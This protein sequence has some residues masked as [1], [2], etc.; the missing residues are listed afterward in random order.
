MMLMDY[1]CAKECKNTEESFGEIC[2][3]CEK[4]GRKF[5]DGIMIDDGGTHP[6]WDGEQE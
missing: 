2:L 5:N 1:V 4:C 3:K 6:N